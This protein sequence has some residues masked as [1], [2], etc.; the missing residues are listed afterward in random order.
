MERVVRNGFEDGYLYDNDQL[1]TL[2]EVELRDFENLKGIIGSTKAIPK[3]GDIDVNKQ[4]VRKDEQY[5]RRG[6]AVLYY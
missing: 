4:G 6:I 5:D 3:S 2:N 1:M